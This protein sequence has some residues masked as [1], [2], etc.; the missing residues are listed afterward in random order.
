MPSSFRS[1]SLQMQAI[2]PLVLE[3]NFP[4]RLQQRD[5]WQ[6]QERNDEPEGLD[7]SGKNRAAHLLCQADGPACTLSCVRACLSFL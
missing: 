4:A 2:V 3:Q 6:P 1:D 5:S 7:L